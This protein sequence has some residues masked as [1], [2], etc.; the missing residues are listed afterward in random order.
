M[1]SLAL[2]FASLTLFAQPQAAPGP[3][4]AACW[5]ALWAR[6][7]EARK[8]ALAAA[9]P[10]VNQRPPMEI[11]VRSAP[12]KPAGE[13]VGTGAAEPVPAAPRAVVEASLEPKALFTGKALE[14]YSRMQARALGEGMVSPAAAV[15][16]FQ[17]LWLVS[18]IGRSGMMTREDDGAIILVDPK[19]TR[20]P[21]RF[22]VVG[23]KPAAQWETEPVYSGECLQ[24]QAA[25]LAG[26]WPKAF[27][28]PLRKAARK[29][30][31]NEPLLLALDL[32]AA[33]DQ[34]GGQEASLQEAAARLA[35]LQP[36]NREALSLCAA[37][38]VAAGKP[39]SAGRLKSWMAWLQRTAP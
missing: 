12:R 27:D 24:L 28:A 23:T 29:T 31:P 22:Y 11:V 17:S 38:Y 13:E 15:L 33:L 21:L 19:G 1:R 7:P 5:A 34:P 39:E 16:K 18:G 37:A 20:W 25:I 36:R 2:A 10:V 26:D 9:P 6:V 8:A 32:L 4:P 30:S 35:A 3:D 14:V